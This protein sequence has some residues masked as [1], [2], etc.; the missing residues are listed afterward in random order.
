MNEDTELKHVA[1]VFTESSFW[2]FMG[3]EIEKLE[4]GEACLR[5]EVREDLMNVINTLHGGVYA[6]IL[7]TT[8]GMTARSIEDVPFAT[9][10]MS[11]HYLR[12]IAQGTVYTKGKLISRSKSLFTVQAEMMDEDNNLAAHSVGSFKV[13]KPR[14]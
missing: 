13:L 9:I 5:L 10:D 8:M 2:K 12:P 4:Q 7:D 6:S 11:V 3:F 14:N 1:A